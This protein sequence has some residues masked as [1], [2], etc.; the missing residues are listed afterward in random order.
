MWG[1]E[2][3]GKTLGFPTLV[4][5]LGRPCAPESPWGLS[6]PSYPV[7]VTYNP[8]SYSVLKWVS[9]SLLCINAGFWIWKVSCLHLFS[10]LVH[11]EYIRFSCQPSHPKTK[12]IL[13]ESWQGLGMWWFVAPLPRTDDFCL[14]SLRALSRVW[15]LLFLPQQQPALTLYQRRA[16]GIYRFCACLPVA[17]DHHLVLVQGPDRGWC[18]CSTLE[19]LTGPAWACT[20]HGA[21]SGLLPTPNLSHEQ[22]AI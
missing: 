4:S 15:N 8:V 17:V 2:G 22:R 14:M 3:G 5:G 10:D 13:L 6:P 9:Q 18:G 20:T 21:L 12:K 7:S 16:R 1:V 19:L 11:G